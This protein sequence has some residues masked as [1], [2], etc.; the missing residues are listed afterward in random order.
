MEIEDIIEMLELTKS[1]FKSDG[2]R[3]VYTIPNSDD[4]SHIFNVFDNN[5]KFEE[6][7][8]EQ[9]INL[10]T[11]KIAFID[12]TGTYECTLFADFE[13]DEYSLE[14]EEV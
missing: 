1:D 3:Y 10:F 14:I 9:E 11:N 2:K 7:L 6:D 5:N 12:N 13:N 8:D 4:F